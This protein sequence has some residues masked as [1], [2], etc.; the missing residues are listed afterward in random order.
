MEKINFKLYETPIGGAVK[1]VG[2]LNPH[3]RMKGGAIRQ[4]NY[5]ISIEGV[6]MAITAKHL[7]HEFKILVPIE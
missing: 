7:Q 2:E 6:S 3:D 5:V 1:V 4:Q